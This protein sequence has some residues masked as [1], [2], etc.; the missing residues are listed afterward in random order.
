MSSEQALWQM[1]CD[2]QTIQQGKWVGDVEG[3]KFK[4]SR[5]M[6]VGMGMGRSEKARY[7]TGPRRLR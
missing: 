6:G 4:E 3:G 7:G 5:Y 1:M 2:G